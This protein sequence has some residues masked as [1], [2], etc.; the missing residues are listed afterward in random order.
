MLEALFEHANQRPEKSME[1]SLEKAFQ[2]LEA[3][4]LLPADAE[5]DTILQDIRMLLG[6]IEFVKPTLGKPYFRMSVTADKIKE[7]K[8]KYHVYHH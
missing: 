1:N 2:E 3:Q 5:R 4:P 6:R 7:L 8:S